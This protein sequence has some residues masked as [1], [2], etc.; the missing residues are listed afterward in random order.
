M[1]SKHPLSSVI[2]TL[3][4]PVLEVL[5]GTNLPLTL[6]DVHRS[7]GPSAASLRGVRR[8]LGRLCEGSVVLKV[9]GGFLLNRDHVATSGILALVGMRSQ[10]YERIAADLAGW[11]PPASA[12]GIFGSFARKDGTADSDIDLVVR[13]DDLDPTL[14]DD[15]ATKVEAW[16]GNPCHIVVVDRAALRRMRRHNDPLLDSWATDLIVVHG[17]AKELVGT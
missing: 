9:P 1:E 10:L 4:G 2:P 11:Q 15:L 14:V 5:A 6:T 7:I 12:A 3:E 17:D 13:G 16:T 8:A